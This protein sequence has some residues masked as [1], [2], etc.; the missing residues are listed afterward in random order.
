VGLTSAGNKEFVEGLNIYD[1]VLVYDDVSSLPGERAVYVD[2]SGSGTVRAGV[3]AHYGDRLA[4]SAVVGATHW[5]EMAPAAGDLDGPRPTFFFAPDRITKRH[6]DWGAGQLD[7]NLAE[8][9]RPF[10]AWS[11]DWLRVERISSEDDIRRTY[12]E[13]LDGKVDP[14][15]GAVVRF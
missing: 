6:A 13:L 1:S 3:H 9:W 5:T 12:L 7:Q 15:A 10:A 4:H 11:S 14:A 8:A 2:I